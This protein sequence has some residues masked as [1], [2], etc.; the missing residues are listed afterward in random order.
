MITSNPPAAWAAS[1]HLVEGLTAKAHQQGFIFYYDGQALLAEDVANIAT[2]AML[3]I[4][5]GLSRSLGLGDFGMGFQIL[6]VPNPVFPLAVVSPPAAENVTDNSA[7]PFSHIAPFLVEVF[8]QEVLACAN[9]LSKLYVLALQL[10]SLPGPVLDRA[11]SPAPQSAAVSA[12]V[13]DFDGLL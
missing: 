3:I 2:D 12:L 13:N 9:D 5:D 11:P 7:V 6:E 10:L 1:H 8:D 4:A